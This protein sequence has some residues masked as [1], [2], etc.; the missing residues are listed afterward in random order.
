MREL[1]LFADFGEPLFPIALVRER[2]RIRSPKFF[3]YF[4]LWHEWTFGLGLLLMRV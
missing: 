3:Y 2:V 4:A 1:M